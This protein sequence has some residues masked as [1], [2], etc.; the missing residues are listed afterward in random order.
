VALEPLVARVVLV[1]LVMSNVPMTPT[2]ELA[3]GVVQPQR[4]KTS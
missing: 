1:V 4:T 3:R 2:A